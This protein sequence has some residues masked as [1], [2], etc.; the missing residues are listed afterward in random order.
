MPDHDRFLG[1]GSSSSP[2]APPHQLTT[3]PMTEEAMIWRS[4][5]PHQTPSHLD[6][7]AS[8]DPWTLV[9]MNPHVA[10]GV[11]ALS[12]TGS[13]NRI[14]KTVSTT[15]LTLW[16]WRAGTRQEQSKW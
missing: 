16:T 9:V 7:S 8:H 10:T 13:P 15:R 14:P 3:Q 2:R 11:T 12:Q 5:Q 4:T 6:S 1:L